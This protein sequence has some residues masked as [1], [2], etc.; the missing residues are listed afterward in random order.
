[1]SAGYFSFSQN[2]SGG[3]ILTD[4][5]KGI[6]EYVY[7]WANSF[8]E[9]NDKA[10]KIG[11]FNLPYCECCGE[12]FYSLWHSNPLH[13]GDSESLFSTYEQVTVFFHLP[14]GEI[15]KMVLD[16]SEDMTLT[17]SDEEIAKLPSI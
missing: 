10:D 1:M 12:R 6:G 17:I 15:K 13:N 11:L 14:T 9:A 16:K 5:T 2:N 7:I 3:V 4:D 8:G